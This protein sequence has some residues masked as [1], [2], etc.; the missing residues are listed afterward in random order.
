[1]DLSNKSN[2]ALVDVLTDIISELRTAQDLDRRDALK[3]AA[4]AIQ[5]ELQNRQLLPEADNSYDPDSDSYRG[6]PMPTLDKF[7]YEPLDLEMPSEVDPID[8]YQKTQLEKTI[9][10]IVN[11]LLPARQ[12]TAIT[13]LYGLFGNKEHTY[14]EIAD[15][16]G[17]PKGRIKQYQINGLRTIRAHKSRSLGLDYALDERKLSKKEIKTRDKYAD[18]LPDKEFKKRY[19]KDWE[20]V[21][22]ATATK[23]AKKKNEDIEQELM[24][25]WLAEKADPCWKGYEMIGM[26]K[27][28][29]KDVPNCVPKKGKK[30]S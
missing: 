12:A 26:K 3:K 14:Q 27:K 6:E 13:L 15:I 24:D 17:V 25:Q 11:Q 22:Y 1:M 28:G 5:K 30:K 10:S 2:E 16:L 9:K 7:E 23:M 19:G 18:D 21:K 8:D 29:N 20:S 4:R